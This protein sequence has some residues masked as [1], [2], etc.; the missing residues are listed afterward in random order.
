MSKEWVTDRAPAEGLDRAA[1]NAIKTYA[2]ARRVVLI[3]YESEGT[4]DHAKALKDIH[5]GK[6]DTHVHPH[7]QHGLTREWE[8]KAIDAVVNARE[9][10]RQT[11]IETSQGNGT[12]SDKPAKPT[13]PSKPRK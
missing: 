12:A 5:M 4:D 9:R 1:G 2:A 10:A 13:K 3:T 11:K 7:T 8:A 6:P